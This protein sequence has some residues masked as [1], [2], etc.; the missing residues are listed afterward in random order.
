MQEN[1]GNILILGTLETDTDTNPYSV[2]WRKESIREIFPELEILTLEDN[3]SNEIWFI[4]LKNI[5]DS[6]DTPVCNFYCGDK[7][8]DFAIQV[9]EVYKH[10]LNPKEIHIIE[11]SRNIT[12]ISATQIREKLQKGEEKWVE[13]NIPKEV[14]KK[15]KAS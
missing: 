1:E 15:I 5:I 3:P 14:Y 2:T 9:L 10:T 4:E 6:L 13:K 7:E 8:N 12:P 11:V